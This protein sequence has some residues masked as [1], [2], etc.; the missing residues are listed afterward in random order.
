MVQWGLGLAV[1]VLSAGSAHAGDFQIDAWQFT[2]SADTEYKVDIYGVRPPTLAKPYPTWVLLHDDH[3]CAY[4]GNVPEFG[5][6][7]WHLAVGVHRPDMVAAYGNVY[8]R[9]NG[10]A[11]QSVG[12]ISGQS[13][14]GLMGEDAGR[15][16][17]ASA[18]A[19]PVTLSPVAVVDQC[20]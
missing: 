16:E 17:V 5:C 18:T 9:T 7:R 15:D 8:C 4:A 1:V 10:S 2:P 20:P 12:Q 13:Q 6:H 11:W 14:P 19:P 3:P